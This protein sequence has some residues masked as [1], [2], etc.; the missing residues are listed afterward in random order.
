MGNTAPPPDQVEPKTKTTDSTAAQTYQVADLAA[1]AFRRELNEVKPG[2][3]DKPGDK[4]AGTPDTAVPE[5]P[6]GWAN[7]ANATKEFGKLKPEFEALDNTEAKVRKSQEGSFVDAPADG[8]GIKRTYNSPELKGY[9]H[10]F[11]KDGSVDLKTPTGETITFHGD[12]ATVKGPPPENKVTELDKTKTAE[13]KG[14]LDKVFNKVTGSFQ[15]GADDS[16]KGTWKLDSQGNMQVDKVPG[17]DASMTIKPPNSKD[18]VKYHAD[19][20]GTKDHPGYSTEATGDSKNGHRFVDYDDSKKGDTDPKTAD[21]KKSIEGF[22]A[23]RD[24][25]DKNPP[26]ALVS[27]KH[28]GD[29]SVTKINI[30]GTTETKFDPPGKNGKLSEKVYPPGHP[31]GM[32]SET[33][34]DPKK[35][36]DGLSSEVRDVNGR[37]KTERVTADGGKEVK[38]SAPGQGLEQVQKFKA[39]ADPVKDSPEWTRLTNSNGVI[40]T[41]FADGKKAT[42][43]PGTDGKAGTVKLQEPE[44]DAAGV[45]Q[46]N[47]DGTPKYKDVDPTEFLKKPLASETLSDGR[48]RETHVDGRTVTTP[49][50]GKGITTTERSGPPASVE[51]KWTPETKPTPE[52]LAKMTGLKLSEPPTEAQKAKLKS[53]TDGVTSI[54]EYPGTPAKVELTYADGTKNDAKGAKE[55]DTKTKG[56]F[57]RD[58]DGN[59]LA[60][61]RDGKTKDGRAYTDIENK[62]GRTRTYEISKEAKEK[63]QTVPDQEVFNNKGEQVQ[64]RKV[65][66]ATGKITTTFME[67]GKPKRNEVIDEKAGT[68]KRSEFDESGKEIPGKTTEGKILRG[69]KGQRLYMDG[70][71]KKVSGLQ[72]P[73]GVRAGDSYKF[74]R[75]ATGDNKG[76]LKGLD[77]ETN[78][79]EKAKLVKDATTGKWRTEPAGGKVP[80]FDAANA[81]TEKVKVKGPDGKEIEIEQFKGTFSTNAKGELVYESGDKGTKQ[82]L[83]GDGSKETYNMRE[84]SRVKED[85]NGRPGPKQ[86]WDGYG[87]KN[88]PE[89]GWRAGT[90]TR[91]PATGKITVKFTEPMANRP[92]EMTRNG[93]GNNDSFEVTFANGTKFG[94]GNWNEG[95]MSRTVGGKTET[96]YNTGTIGSD[97]R[98]QWAKG[99]ADAN[100]T[101]KFDDP[102]VQTGDIPEEVRLGKNPDGSVKVDARYKDGT[103]ASGDLNGKSRKTRAGHRG[104]PELERKYG[105]QGDLKSFNQ[106][107]TTGTIDRVDP[108]TGKSDWTININGKDHKIEGATVTEKPGG[109]FEI[110]GKDGA[111]YESNGRMTTKEGGKDVVYDARGQK[112]TKTENAVPADN[113]KTPPVP[114]KPSTWESGNPPKKFPGEMKMYDNGNVAIQTG[115]KEFQTVNSDGTVSKLD[116]NGIERERTD[117]KDGTYQKRGP[118]GELVEFKSKDG[119]VTKLEY[120]R[121]P[122]TN[123]LAGGVKKVETTIPGKDGKPATTRTETRDNPAPPAKPALRTAEGN[124]VEYDRMGTRSEIKGTATDNVTTVTDVHGQSR[125][126]KTEKGQIT[127]ISPGTA[128]DTKLKPKYDKPADTAPASI[129]EVDAAGKEKDTYTK[130]A[131]E[132]NV[133]ESKTTKGKFTLNKD[134]SLKP[135]ENNIGIDPAF[136]QQLERRAE[137]APTGGDK[138]AGPAA[139]TFEEVQAKYGLDKDTIPKLKELV[140]SGPLA[141][142]AEKVTPENLDKLFKAAADS[143]INVKEVFSPANM[144]QMKADVE[145][146]IAEAKKNPTD[147]NSPAIKTLRSL[148]QLL[149]N[150]AGMAQNPELANLA[151]AA[152]QS[153][154]KLFNAK[155][156]TSMAAAVNPPAPGKS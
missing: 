40:E 88:N 127:E 128:G 38:I 120:D 143:G 69:E 131:G 155:F 114:G 103:L 106:G 104:A 65:D 47:P 122:G 3:T 51:H 102:R 1:D 55:G 50:D 60:E 46:K 119:S 28:A 25:S 58:G 146:L 12:T 24:A 80:G 117:P 135:A 139:K 9:E 72:I 48:T 57:L 33:T 54:T 134:G 10:T 94:V 150:P 61:Q 31:S 99:T 18:D 21:G 37:S 79:G 115:E 52:Q 100:G 151:A 138:P 15:T 149:Q 82:I 97:G 7:D 86:Y 2:T 113:T 77:I 90:E 11:K 78:K 70:D 29:G 71:G 109:K 23:K 144:Q 56:A 39:G 63:G 19:V 75:E 32:A 140:A 41:H 83:R 87:S 26:L 81:D 14:E 53:L 43:T 142:L 112:W 20:K 152:P 154:R 145:G 44:K 108:V 133:Y 62:N 85:A 110:V 34:F 125:T 74:D 59:I 132:E 4:P 8:G 141:G 124:V 123:E 35:H 68:W 67:G 137:A 64:D 49:K 91:D 92:T 116:Q 121:K 107:T 95:K 36:P 84:Y 17:L 136:S 93:S 45:V 66:P 129:S 13:K 22:V 111:K 89:D 16:S 130:V 147:E 76:E 6:N 148:G 105:P 30:D 118:Q 98:V 5:M 156:L 96:L 27:D 101:V 153:F 42:F 126:I 73:G